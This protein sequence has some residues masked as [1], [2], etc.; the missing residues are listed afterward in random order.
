M[1]KVGRNHELTA[2]P[3][4]LTTIWPANIS[5]HAEPLF[6]DRFAHCSAWRPSPGMKPSFKDQEGM[7]GALARKF[8]GSANDRRIRAYQPRVDAINALEAEYE[9]LSDEELNAK[10]AGFRQ[11]L[12]GLETSD[13]IQRALDDLL[14]P[15]FATV[16]EA[17]KR[18]LGQRHF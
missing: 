1:R 2:I 6:C 8:F 5:R 17:S 4:P 15:A 13:E 7:I 3:A 11:R 10:T 9:K 12:V 16:R 14:V 18:T